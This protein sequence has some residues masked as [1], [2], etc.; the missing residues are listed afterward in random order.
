MFVLH[1]GDHLAATYADGVLAPTQAGHRDLLT[2]V[3]LIDG[4]LSTADVEVSNSVTSAPEVL[5]LS[6]DIAFVAERLAQRGPGDTTAAQLA[7]GMQLTAIDVSNRSAPLVVAQVSVGELPEALAVSPDGSTVAVVSNGGGGAL[8]SLVPWDGGRFG[9]PR[10]FPIL[11]ADSNVT[12][13]HWHPDGD[14]LAVNNNTEDRVEFLAVGA[15]GVELRDS[16]ATGPDPF[17]GRF[18][19]DGAYYLTSNWGRDLNAPS[20][21]ERLPSRPSTVSVIDVEGAEVIGTI[22]S[23]RSAEGLAVSADGAWVATVNMRGTALPT[24]AAGFDEQA[25]VSLFRFEGGELTKVGDSPLDGVLPEGGA[26]DPSGRYFVASVFEGRP[27]GPGPGLQVYDVGADG[28]V[29]VQRI[30][31]P[32][33]AHHVVFGSGPNPLRQTDP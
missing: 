30:A 25:S 7:P 23:D 9:Q 27:G 15:R 28:L 4:Q 5:G 13:V 19:P 17:V 16:V 3:S 6:G 1:D 18:T 22:D 31:L 8:L 29:P 11:G 14:L 33:G 20:I 10:A 12:N 24:D 26:F 2:T 32:H 21:S